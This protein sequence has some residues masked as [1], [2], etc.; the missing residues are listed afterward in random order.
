[1]LSARFTT[2]GKNMSGSIISE[3]TGSCKRGCRERKCIVATASSGHTVREVVD[4]QTH[5]HCTSGVE[6]LS[7]PE[8]IKE[9]V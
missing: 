6:S 8:V 3:V 7:G 2:L 1:M 9:M 5:T 4:T